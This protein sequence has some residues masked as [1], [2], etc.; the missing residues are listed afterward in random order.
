[1]NRLKAY[2]QI[3]NLTQKD[4][5]DVLG[6][7]PQM[8]GHVEQD[9]R[10]LSFDIG[11]LG[12]SNER[13][14]VPDMSEPLHR[15][16]AATL[17][18]STNRAKELVRLGGEVFDELRRRNPRAPQVTIDRLP[19]PDSVS[20]VEEVAIDVRLILG[21]EESGPIR[22]LTS[23]V[24]R[25]GVCLVPL[26]G[27]RGIDGMSSWVSDQPVVG[28]SPTVGGDRFRFSLA[29]ELA[30]LILHRQKAEFTEDQA[31]RFAG[32]LLFPEADFEAAMPQTPTLGDFINLKGTWGVSVAALVYRAHELGYIDD[33][34]YRSIQIQM[35]RWRR[36]EPGQFPIAP[37]SLL[38]RLIDAAGGV[39]LVAEELG[40]NRSHIRELT[41]W[42]H[43]RVA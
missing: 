6:V 4:L 36:Q 39:D 28:I 15:Q 3:E 11:V 30:H 37:G 21:V 22:N 35:A 8:I 27:L 24:E 31:N 2:R 13:F 20:D 25:A 23:V 12:Y 41:N 34:R 16:R 19:T 29:H 18:A 43:L 1:M 17:A 38:A 9:R 14:H 5:S 26:T 7:S 42:S 10:G 40:M 32:A 33:Q